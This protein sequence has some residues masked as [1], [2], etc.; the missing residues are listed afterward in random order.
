LRHRRLPYYN[1]TVSV[2]LCLSLVATDF[3]YCC[4]LHNTVT[5]NPK[6][7]LSPSS[8]CELTTVTLSLS[9]VYRSLLGR[10]PQAVRKPSPLAAAN[11]TWLNS[12]NPTPAFP[13]HTGPYK[14]GSLDVEIPTSQLE[15]PSANPSPGDLPTVA[16]RVFYPCKQESDQTGVRWIPS[17]QRE[18]ISAYAKFLGANSAFASVFS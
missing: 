1:L 18:Y 7:F 2:P 9:R 8:T 13:A 14:V 6:V 12:L 3:P 4:V 5:S 11:M 16:F 17:P 10:L 15:S